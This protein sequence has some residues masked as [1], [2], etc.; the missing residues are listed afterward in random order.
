MVLLVLV[1][2]VLVLMLVLVI[3]RLRRDFRGNDEMLAAGVI[4]LPSA[5][6]I[7]QTVCKVVDEEINGAT[8]IL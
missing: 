2:L 1:E 6:V 5:E 8:F 3:L 7:R 4:R